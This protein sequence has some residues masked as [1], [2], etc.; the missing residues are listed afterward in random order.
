MPS[1]SPSMVYGMIEKQKYEERIS[2]LGDKIDAQTKRVERLEARIQVLAAVNERLKNGE[3]ID[4]VDDENM[5]VWEMDLRQRERHC[6]ELRKQNNELTYKLELAESQL[7]TTKELAESI[8]SKRI[9][10]ESHAS[11][12]E[13]IVSTQKQNVKAE[14]RSDTDTVKELSKAIEMERSMLSK[15]IS[16]LTAHLDHEK[17]TADEALKQQQAK[18]H[19]EFKEQLTGTENS[20]VEQLKKHEER[21]LELTTALRSTLSDTELIAELAKE[22]DCSRQQQQLAFDRLKQQQ[23]DE[24]EQI[25]SGLKAEYADKHKLL[26]WEIRR[27]ALITERMA[28]QFSAFAVEEAK[29]LE[30]V[31]AQLVDNYHQLEHTASG[32]GMR[33]TPMKATGKSLPD[34]ILWQPRIDL[35]RNGSA[36][37]SRG[38]RRDATPAVASSR[39]VAAIEGAPLASDNSDGTSAGATENSFPLLIDNQIVA[40][41]KLFVQFREIIQRRQYVMVTLGEE[42]DN[43][44]L[45]VSKDLI[46]TKKDLINAKDRIVEQEKVLVTVRTELAKKNYTQ[47]MSVNEYESQIQELEFEIKN[48]R[49]QRQRQQQLIEDLRS[50]QEKYDS[51]AF[52]LKHQVKEHEITIFELQNQLKAMQLKAQQAGSNQ[53]AVPSSTTQ[54]E[55]T[56]KTSPRSI[57]PTPVI[58][59]QYPEGSLKEKSDMKTLLDVAKEKGLTAQQ[60]LDNYEEGDASKLLE[61]LYAIPPVELDEEGRRNR[62]EAI[63]IFEEDQRKNTYKQQKVR[64]EFMKLRERFRLEAVRSKMNRIGPNDA[65][66]QAL[67]RMENMHRVALQQWEWKRQQLL[68]ERKAKLINVLMAFSNI[69]V[70][71]GRPTNVQLTNKGVL[72]RPAQ[73]LLRGPV[74]APVGMPFHAMVA[75]AG[76]IHGTYTGVPVEPTF[77]AR[78]EGSGVGGMQTHLAAATPGISSNASAAAGQRD[79]AGGNHALLSRTL[80]AT[81]NT[82]PKPRLLSLLGSSTEADKLLPLSGIKGDRAPIKKATH[83]QIYYDT[84]TAKH[85]KKLGQLYSHVLAPMSTHPTPTP[86]STQISTQPPALL[87]LPAASPPVSPHSRKQRKKQDQQPSTPPEQPPPTQPPPPQAQQPPAQEPPPQVQ[88]ASRPQTGERPPSGGA[89]SSGVVECPRIRTPK[90]GGRDS[91]K[92]TQPQPKPDEHL[93]PLTPKKTV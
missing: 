59:P 27:M 41:N 1:P 40:M 35:S 58:Q 23:K 16:D 71:K 57:A 93:P 75:P 73:D 21:T 72:E 37:V 19:A 43:K 83:E 29:A 80:D 22:S 49:T 13:W 11:S 30:D 60:V 56:L 15:Q 38:G 55:N 74:A 48:L 47:G 17:K 81:G 53:G 70:Y 68:A 78:V 69:V 8:D 12:L 88:P 39:P 9:V 63:R 54:Q 3:K 87:P 10:L 7:A 25:E 5:D 18:L 91:P 42:K 28:A 44:L 79:A 64:L 24:L 34:D 6:L 50:R 86:A 32:A 67:Q 90:S 62:E 20:Y 77:D 84:I 82:K 4:D 85:M 66:S 46:T 89:G 31:A 36:A 14:T 45:S 92:P 51:V 26:E 61:A 52:K 2:E 65:M 76:I 33:I